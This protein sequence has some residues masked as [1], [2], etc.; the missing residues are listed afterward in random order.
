[1]PKHETQRAMIDRQA[2]VRWQCDVRPGHS[3]KVD[4]VGIAK[5]KGGD[6]SLV[7]K[8]PSCRIPGCPGIVLFEEALGI[9]RNRLETYSDRDPEWWAFGERRRQQLQALGWRVE[10][11]KWRSADEKGP[12]Y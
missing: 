1:M 12:F 11:G 9:R 2:D 4:L 7:N 6:Y 5:A 10:M 8:R 3:G